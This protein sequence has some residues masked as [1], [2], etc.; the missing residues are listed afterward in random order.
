MRMRGAHPMTDDDPTINGLDDPTRQLLS[1]LWQR[2]AENEMRTSTV[3]ANLYLA[4]VHEAAHPT[5]LAIA[6]AAVADELRHAEIATKVA[7][8]YRGRPTALPAVTPLEA[9]LFD[10][11]TAAESRLLF[12]ILQSCLNETIAAA[13]LKVCWDQAAGPIVRGALH[14]ILQ[15]EIEHS[16]L[17]WAHLGSD[18][19]NGAMREMVGQALPQLL[20]AV[21]PQWLDDPGGDYARAPAGH[22]TLAP[23]VMVGLVREAIERIILPGFEH[24][25]VDSRAARA[26][27]TKT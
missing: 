16:R 20:A 4:L 23:S 21:V 24:V 13:Y 27:M 26:W 6:A 8:R 2:R 15:D 3:F 5:V 18:R 25:G 7:A 19:V 22:G 1:V 9:P 10:G 12:P 17:G 11:C 14:S